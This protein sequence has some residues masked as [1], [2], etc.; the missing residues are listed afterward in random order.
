MKTFTV[1]KE[2]IAP[3]VDKY[4]LSKGN[5]VVWVDAATEQVEAAE[6]H[7]PSGG[8]KVDLN[9]EGVAGVQAAIEAYKQTPTA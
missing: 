9:A 3:N 7:Y 6:R 8:E 4:V 2:T 5:L 1:T